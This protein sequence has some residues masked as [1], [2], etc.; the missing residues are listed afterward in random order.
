MSEMVERVAAAICNRRAGRR[1][2]PSVANVV[3]MLRSIGGGTLV[4]EAMDDAHAAIAAMREPSEAMLVAA[5]EWSHA[6]YGAAI[7]NDA[8]LGLFQAMIDAA[9]KE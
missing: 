5:R 8:A 9:L 2:M 7:G 6:K 4:D 1:G 3:E